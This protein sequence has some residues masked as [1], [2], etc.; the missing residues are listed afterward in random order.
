MLF[1]MR[2]PGLI[3]RGG[4]WIYRREVPPKLRSFIG[5][6]EIKESLRT[7]DERGARRR[8]QG[9]DAHLTMLL[10]EQWNNQRRLDPVEH[11]KILAL[12]TRSP[13][14][15]ESDNPP[16]SLIF[17]RHQ[18]ERKLP[19]KTAAEWTKVLEKFTATAGDLPVRSINQG[20]IRQFKASLL[21]TLGA[22]L[23]TEGKPR[24]LSAATV[25]KMLG[26]L[27][28][29]L[30]WAKNEGFIPLNPAQ[31]ITVPL[32]RHNDDT[33]RHVSRTRPRSSR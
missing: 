24:P 2:L 21:G 28:S 26:A 12:L 6:R 4:A 27:S 14:E 18:A 29:V 3:K 33:T 10:D 16:I 11:A 13:V 15:Q 19:A 31:G 32:P 25:R 17:E 23:D 1:R 22:R 9:L 8:W 7:T 20:H 5:K 30:T